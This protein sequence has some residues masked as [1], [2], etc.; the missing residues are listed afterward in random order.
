MHTNYRLRYKFSGGLDI[1]FYKNV[2]GDKGL[3][4][5][6]I[7]NDFAITWNHS[8]DSKASPNQSLA[9]VSTFHESYDQNNFIHNS[10]LP[11]QYETIECIL[12]QEMGKQSFSLCSPTCDIRRIAGILPLT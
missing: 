2:F 4:D 10:E 8:M 6:K 7:Q 3:P 9:Q 1:N 5:Y 12:Y 11:H